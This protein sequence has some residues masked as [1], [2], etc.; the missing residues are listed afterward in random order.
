M[1]QKNDWL[2]IANPPEIESTLRFILNSK[3]LLRMEVEDCSV[4]V[5]TTILEIDAGTLVIDNSA[6]D[7]ISQ[8]LIKAESVYLEAAL[9]GMQIS[10]VGV[11]LMPWTHA[12]RPALRLALP[13]SL[14]RM[15]RRESART[16]VPIQNPALCTLL[17]SSRAGQTR[18]ELNNISAG[19]VSLIDGE[20]LL[21][22]TDGM[23]Y[24]D[25]QLELPDV[26]IIKMGLRVVHSTD[27]RLDNGKST[28]CVGCA[29][30]DISDTALMLVRHYAWRL[31]YTHNAHRPDFK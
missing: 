30:I 27:T 24:A 8:E 26:G 20:R 10:F 13:Q 23:R 21:D 6:S 9:K 12:G 7:P 2:N 31:E 11:N 29:F 3:T 1:H 19:G 15:Q 5:I 16:R 4:S 25:C 22:I 18:L 28:R 14:R 17:A